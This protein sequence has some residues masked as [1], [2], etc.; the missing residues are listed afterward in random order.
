MSAGG[1]R[2]GAHVEAAP[3]RP[4]A[5]SRAVVVG[6]AGA[7]GAAVVDDLATAGATVLAADLRGAGA[8]VAGRDGGGHTAAEVDVTDLASVEA[9][10]ARAFADG[11]VHAVVY[12]AGA[13]TTGPIT[14]LDWADYDRVMDVNLRGAF[15]LAKA[16]SG[17]LAVQPTPAS[18]VLLAS[19]AGQRGEAG[20]SV[21]CASKFGLIGLMQ[22]LAA[23]LAPAGVRVNAVAPGNVDSPMLRELAARVAAR[24]DRDATTVLDALADEAAQRRLVGVGEVAAACTWLVSPAS[25]GVTGTTVNVDGGMLTA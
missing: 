18:L 9:L 15:H 3:P 19:T 5:G 1:S 7:I 14:E 2:D 4:L 6:A 11:E 8:V 17:P 24:E 16:V 13:N 23:E 20:G 25:S 22:S 12:A 21:Y 10:V